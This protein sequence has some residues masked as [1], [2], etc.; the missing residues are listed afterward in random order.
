MSLD[1]RSEV[2][3]VGA[4]YA[5]SVMARELAAAGHRVHIIDKRP[6]IAGNAL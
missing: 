6:H 3:I 5:G 4:G 2:L 1:L